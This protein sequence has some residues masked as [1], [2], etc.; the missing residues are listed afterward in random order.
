MTS[1][2]KQQCFTFRSINPSTVDLCPAEA[3]MGAT[4][5]ATKTAVFLSAILKEL[6]QTS[7][8]PVEILNDS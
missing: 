8:K 6:H 1:P 3:E 4:V 5:D 2:R 7:T